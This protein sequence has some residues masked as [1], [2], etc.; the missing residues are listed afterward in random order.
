MTPELESIY[1]IIKTLSIFPSLSSNSLSLLGWYWSYWSV[2][3]K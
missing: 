1:Y 2:S 3:F